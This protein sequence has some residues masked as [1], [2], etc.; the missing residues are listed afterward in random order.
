MGYF[1]LQEMAMTLQGRASPG[2]AKMCI[3]G[4]TVLT[5]IPGISWV[6]VLVELRLPKGWLAP[7]LPFCGGVAEVVGKDL[8]EMPTK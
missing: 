4:N 5:G 7:Y 2:K 6:D 3:H 1:F 8:I